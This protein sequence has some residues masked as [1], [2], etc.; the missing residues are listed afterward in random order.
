MEILFT[1]WLPPVLLG[2]G[3][4]MLLRTKGVGPRIAGGLL[5]F[6]GGLLTALEIWIYSKHYHR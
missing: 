2:L 4:Y 6:V 1:P 5:A 3:I